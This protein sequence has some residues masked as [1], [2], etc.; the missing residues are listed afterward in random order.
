[1]TFQAKAPHKRRRWLALFAIVILATGAMATSTLAAIPAF[2]YTQDDAGANDE[3]GQKDLTGQATG[4]DSGHFYTA[5]AWDD[6]SW[7]GKNT[8]DACSLFDTSSPKDG[9]VDYAVCAT[10]GKPAVEKST[11]VY[12]CGNTREDRCTGSVLIGT[13]SSSQVWCTVSALSPGVFA[14]SQ[15]TQAA[16]DITQ[17][18]TD[19]PLS[20]IGSGTLVNSCSYPSQQPNSDPSDCVITPVNEDTSLTTLSSGSA[21]WSATLDDTTTMNPTTATGSVVF[22]LWSDNLC[23]TLV[24]ESAGVIVGAGGVASTVGAGTTTG[25]NVITDA[26]V[27]GDGVYYWTADFTSS[28]LFNGS[29]SSCGEATTITPASVGGTAG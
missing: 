2:T 10:I 7:S 23:T 1:V 28:D 12:S 21:T 9:L 8:G 17:I 27:D 14:D 29:S 25:S 15:D 24:W 16:C 20:I 13:E 22:K 6:T 11:R 5:W 18:A 3:P 4:T 19:V 26:T